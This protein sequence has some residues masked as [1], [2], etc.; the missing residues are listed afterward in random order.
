MTFNGWPRDTTESVSDQQLLKL[1]SKNFKL[2]ALCSAMC[3]AGRPNSL[4]F[5][6][7]HRTAGQNVRSR[8]FKK[9]FFFLKANHKRADF[10]NQDLFW[11]LK[12]WAL[13]EDHPLFGA[14]HYTRHC[15]IAERDHSSTSSS[16]NPT[17]DLLMTGRS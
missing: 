14:L 9:L 15:D 5:C 6:L 7:W 10:H 13:A 17:H 2:S 1:S 12:L 8:A 16:R 4:D 11:V 3:R